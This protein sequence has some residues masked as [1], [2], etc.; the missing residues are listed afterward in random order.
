M[1]GSYHSLSSMI[2][3]NKWKFRANKI[4]RNVT[5][6]FH[7]VSHRCKGRQKDSQLFVKRIRGHGGIQRLCRHIDVL[8]YT[9]TK[10]GELQRARDFDT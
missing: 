9:G 1:I 7:I 6:L 10:M 4:T 8:V 5:C 3:S 2:G